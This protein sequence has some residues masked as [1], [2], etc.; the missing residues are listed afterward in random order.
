MG[1]MVAPYTL[2][3]MNSFKYKNFDFSFIFTGKFGHVFQTMG[4]NYPPTWNSRVLPNSKLAEVN[5]ADPANMVPLPLN[6]DDAEYYI[7]SYVTGSMDYLIQSASHVRLQ[8]IYLGYTFPES[9]TKR[10][11]INNVLLYAQGNN[12][13]SIY[14]NQ[15]GED[16]EFPMGG[17]RLMPSYT[18][19]LKF[20][21]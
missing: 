10:I 18:F 13:F 14:S 1:T 3:F 17:M 4:F 6:K 20:D 21:F 12:L 19:G 16:P 5:A 2:G 11:G 7:W 15:A 8:E 9:L